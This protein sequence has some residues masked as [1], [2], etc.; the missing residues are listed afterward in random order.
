[1]ETVE[2]AELGRVSVVTLMLKQVLDRN[3]KDPRKRNVMKNRMLIVQFRV[4]EMVM[5][6]FF[7]AN[8]VRAEEGARSKPDIEIAGNMKTLLSIALGKSPLTALFRRQLRVRIKRLKG[9]LY[10]LRV[11]LLMQLGKPPAYLR[12]L[13]AKEPQEDTA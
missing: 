2:V 9:Y 7:E 6:L 8:R 13:A 12:W 5:T 1:M 10:I 11:L 4:R 3:L